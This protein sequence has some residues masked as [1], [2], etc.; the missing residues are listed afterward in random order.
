MVAR[1]L[2]ALLWIAAVTAQLLTTITAMVVIVFA[3]VV[4][5][6]TTVPDL[7]HATRSGTAVG[8]A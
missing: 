6:P 3:V 2:A 4:G 5:V 8:T 1:A 7:R